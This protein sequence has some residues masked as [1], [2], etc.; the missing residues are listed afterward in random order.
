MLGTNLRFY[1][2]EWI[3]T[4]ESSFLLLR[5]EFDISILLS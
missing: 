3:I 1:V 4:F 2:I 5:L